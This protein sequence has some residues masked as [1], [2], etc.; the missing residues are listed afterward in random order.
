M[1]MSREHQ[2]EWF[3]SSRA[4]DLGIVHVCERLHKNVPALLLFSYIMTQWL[5][6]SSVVSFGLHIGLGVIR[7]CCE[8]LPLKEVAKGFEE[9]NQELCA[10]V[11]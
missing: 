1:G 9:F 2:A 5:I 10:V 6:Q 7:C 11:C 3:S 4:A 8:A